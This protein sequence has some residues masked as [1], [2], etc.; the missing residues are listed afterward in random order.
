MI[1]ITLPLRLLSEANQRGSW[2]A[3]AKRAKKERGVVRIALVSPI[4]GA[5][6]MRGSF[7][8]H[9][10]LD[11]G[12]RI[13]VTLTR[14]APRRL[15]GDNLQRACKAVRDGVADA[16][17]V[18]DGDERIEWRYEQRRHEEHEHTLGR[19]VRGYGV[20][21]RI[22]ARE[23]PQHFVVAQGERYSTKDYGPPL[24]GTNTVITGVDNRAGTIALREA[25]VPETRA[26]ASLTATPAKL[27]VSCNDAPAE[28]QH[29]VSLPSAKPLRK[30][31]K[32]R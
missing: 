13:A 31:S 24:P 18:D 10:R 4:R 17:G 11:A 3:G 16:L 29:S 2:H 28:C 21:I 22:E 12:Q 5:G 9:R 26:H 32:V 14:I 15:D 6:L 30:R 7:L 20:E 8:G 19:V 1:A 23:A 25:A 27:G